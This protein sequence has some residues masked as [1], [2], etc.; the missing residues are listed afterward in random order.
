[1][2]CNKCG[3]NNPNNSKY[4]CH[5]GA[6]MTRRQR[7]SEN[8]TLFVL[9][10]IVII[11][12]IFAIAGAVIVVNKAAKDNFSEHYNGLETQMPEHDTET[13]APSNLNTE[14]PKKTPIPDPPTETPEPTPKPTE[15][16]T[17]KPVTPVVSEKDVFYEKAAAIQNYSEKY[18][19]T[20]A[21]QH[22]LNRESGIVF[23]KWDDLLNDVY[24]Y[25]KITLSKSEF[26]KLQ[27]DELEWITEKENAIKKA[28]AD[29]SGGS[30]EPYI[31]NT[32][33]IYYTEERCYY[34][35]SL[36]D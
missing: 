36:V 7:D 3:G 14:N 26:E 27:K 34:L 23:E 2:I 20:A 1:M 15:K 21:S 25:L 4:C 22:D 29:W 17:P 11:I 32:T 5:C 19:E 28:A 30:G 31:R 8:K 24:D 6:E 16:P 12:A 13:S 35:I 9:L 10:I 33:G 18:L